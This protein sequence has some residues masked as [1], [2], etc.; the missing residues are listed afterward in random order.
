MKFR[1]LIALIITGSLVSCD[2]DKEVPPA[3]N[4]GTLRVQFSAT[5]DGQPMVLN[6][7]HTG[8]FGY[9]IKP[10]TLKYLLHHFQLKKTDGTWQEVREALLINHANSTNQFSVELDPISYTAVKFGL[11]VD[12]TMNNA[13]P[14]LLPASHPF[15]TNQAND[16]HWSWSTGYI[17]AK[18]EGR[19]DTSGSG[20][21]SLNRLFFFHPGANTLYGDVELNKN[22]TITKG[23]TTTLNVQLDVHRLLTGSNDTI[24]LKTDYSTHTNDNY[25]LAE[26]YILLMREAFSIQ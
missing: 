20:S 12:A 8:S 14:N 26:R 1:I 7:T 18:Y 11:G 21:G 4:K 23:Q 22:F 9:V 25:P 15:S 5:F 3:P 24:N 16:L 17:F 10:E 19:A 6:N 13:D 2:R